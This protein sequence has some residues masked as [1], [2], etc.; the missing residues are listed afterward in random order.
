MILILISTKLIIS[1]QYSF[2][3]KIEWKNVEKTI[4]SINEKN[5]GT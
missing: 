3:N 5:N 1:F 4:N 2:I